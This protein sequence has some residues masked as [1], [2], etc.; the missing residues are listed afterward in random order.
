MWDVLWPKQTKNLGKNDSKLLLLLLD[1]YFN[2][3]YQ[4]KSISRLLSVPNRESRGNHV[5]SLLTNT[6]MSRVDRAQSF[7]THNKSQWQPKCATCAN[8]FINGDTPTEALTDDWEQEEQRKW[9]TVISTHDNK[10]AWMTFHS[11]L[12]WAAKKRQRGVMLSTQT[13]QEH[14]A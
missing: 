11:S 14:K 5:A 12:W 10:T 7:H 9:H 13:N 6:Q 1:I 2:F 8:S 3:L 4:L